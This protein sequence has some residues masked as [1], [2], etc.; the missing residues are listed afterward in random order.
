M[1]IYRSQVRPSHPLETKE[2]FSFSKEDCA[3][4]YPL[5][6]V[7]SCFFEASF[8]DDEGFL[9]ASYRIFGTMLL[10]DSRTLKEF[11][12]P[13]E[14]EGEADI[15]SSEEEEGD[16][17]IFPG[18]FFESEDLAHKI[19]KTLVPLSPRQEGSALPSSGE[20]YQV[21]SEEEKREENADSPF[22]AI[23]EDYAK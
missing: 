4:D 9:Y 12:F 15:L 5:L 2:K 14:E 10:S 1:R 11:A 20:G 6:S 22:E 8:Q 16:G 23:P 18:T 7:P 3:K 19:I 13:F 21:L 17:Y